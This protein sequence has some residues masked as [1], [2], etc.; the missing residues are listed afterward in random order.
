MLGAWLA[1]GLARALGRPFVHR[2]LTK[3]NAQYVD[4]WVATHGGG[5]LLVCRLIPV[6]AFNLINYAAGLTRVSWWTFTWSTGIGIL[7]LTI[8]MVVMGDQI[9]K[10]P[11]Q[12][13]FVLLIVG[14]SCWAVVRHLVSH[15]SE[16]I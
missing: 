6:I 5:A 16:N 4:V 2:M 1:F 12:F 11:W 14:L 3:K 9:D 10:F 7:P 13:W 15:K 8:L